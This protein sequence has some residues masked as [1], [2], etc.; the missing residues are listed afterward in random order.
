MVTV[1]AGVPVL[2]FW[3]TPPQ[4]SVVVA[5]TK[6]QKVDLSLVSVNFSEQELQDLFSKGGTMYI[7]MKRK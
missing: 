6:V 2:E 1:A 3:A 5:K 4:G 7:F